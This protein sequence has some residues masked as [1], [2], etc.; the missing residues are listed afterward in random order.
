MKKRLREDRESLLLILS[1]ELKNQRIE[2]DTKTFEILHIPVE[3]SHLSIIPPEYHFCGCV[4]RGYSGAK[5]F[6]L[7]GR[8]SYWRARSCWESPH[9]LIRAH[10]ALLQISNSRRQRQNLV[11]QLLFTRRLHALN[12]IHHSEMRVGDRHLTVNPH[13][14]G[15]QPWNRQFNPARAR[16]YNFSGP[17]GPFALQLGVRSS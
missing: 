11:D 1:Q 13:I 12:H 4:T 9:Y 17:F 15:E 14:P 8:S 16:T 5:G 2:N 7:N 3:L 10:A 6:R